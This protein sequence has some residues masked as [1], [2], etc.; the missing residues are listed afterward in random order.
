MS[1]IITLKKKICIYTHTQT[2]TNI[3]KAH[4]PSCALFN[5]VELKNFLRPLNQK[6]KKGNPKSQTKNI[7]HTKKICTHS[8]DK[9]KAQ[10]FY[11]SK[12]KI[13]VMR[14]WSRWEWV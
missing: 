4:D 9:L 1:L 2:H 13:S 8:G 6:K 3:V 11:K 14:G 10:S 12:K 5:F 7:F